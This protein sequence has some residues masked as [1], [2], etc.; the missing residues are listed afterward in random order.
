[1]FEKQE[2]TIIGLAISIFVIVL[3]VIAILAMVN[4]QPA[5]QTQPELYDE[6]ALFEPLDESS[7]QPAKPST[8]ITT[9]SEMTLNDIIRSAR[10]WGPA[11][12]SWYGKAAP[13]FTLPDI[14]G[15]QHKLSDYRGKNVMIIFWAAWCGPCRVEIPHLIE[16]RRTVSEDKL[17]MLAITNEKLELA[18]KFVTHQKM[19]YTVLLEKGN[20]PKP[21]GF[22]RVYGTSGVP[23]SFFIDPSGRIKI[24]TIGVVPLKDI[25]PILQAESGY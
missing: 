16:L 12:Q 6:H 19:N 14:K 18:K 10:T 9:S 24:A 3:V 4:R 5:K 1:M 11:Y 20:M 2:R 15:E 7:R 8:N 17:A 25:K 22:M 23:C 13:D 21:F